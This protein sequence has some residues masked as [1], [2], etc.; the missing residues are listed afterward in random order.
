MNQLEKY[1]FH[2]TIFLVYNQRLVNK[3]W[4]N[5]VEEE[6]VRSTEYFHCLRAA[7]LIPDDQFTEVLTN[8][9]TPQ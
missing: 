1:N 2:L 6:I 8:N 9:N 4:K 5:E 3:D 7:S